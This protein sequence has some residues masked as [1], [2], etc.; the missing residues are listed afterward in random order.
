MTKI[1][2]KQRAVLEWFEAAAPVGAPVKMDSAQID[3]AVHQGSANI[4]KIVV[5]LV[6]KG[7]LRRVKT[8]WYEVKTPSA[9]LRIVQPGRVTSR[10]SRQYSSS[11][12]P[13]IPY[14]GAEY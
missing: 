9:A 5:V 8:G 13:L 12:R 4:Q 7:V 11:G 1:T 6:K 14:A 2:P 3:A 10:P